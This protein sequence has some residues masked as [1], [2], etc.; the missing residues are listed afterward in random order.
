MGFRKL[1]QSFGELVEEWYLYFE[2]LKVVT[3]Q[4]SRTTHEDY[5]GGIRK[6][7]HDYWK[8]PAVEVTPYVVT[9]VFEAMKLKGLCFGHGKKLKQVLKSIFDF[10]IQSGALPYLQRSPLFSAL[11]SVSNSQAAS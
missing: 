2:K 4:R 9:E 8:R 3:R 6:W 5:L 11:E 7:F 10:G 1:T